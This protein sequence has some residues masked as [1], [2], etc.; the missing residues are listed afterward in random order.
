MGDYKKAEPL[1]ER[2][3]KIR[4]KVLGPEHHDTATALNNVASL[5]CHMGNYGKAEPLYERSLKILEKVLGP[6]HPN[7][8]D[9]LNNLAS[10]YQN[11]GYYKIAEPLYERSLKI[12]EKAL[13][14]EHPGTAGSLNNLAELC[15]SMGDYGKAEPLHER[16]LKILEK[17]LGPEHAETGVSYRN[18]AVC[19]FFKDGKGYEEWVRKW[20]KTEKAVWE[21]V[22]SFTSERQ[23]MAFQ[24][25]R[26]PFSLPMSLGMVP[27]SVDAL[28]RYK[29]IVLDSMMEDSRLGRSSGNP[30]VEKLVDA[31][32]FAVAKLNKV[33]QEAEKTQSEEERQQHRKE[34]EAVKAEVEGIQKELARKV[35]GHGK[36]R[37]SL[38]IV[39]T[40][41]QENLKTQE[42]L[43]EFIRYN[44]SYK[45]GGKEKKEA[46]YGV[47]LIPAKGIALKGKKAG[48]V[49]F[50]IA[51][52]AEEI[53]VAMAIGCMTN[54]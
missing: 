20:A 34:V 50:V 36:S 42:V 35:V 29:G 8:A 52:K 5:Y 41:V 26:D 24:S 48:E 43:L 44:H 1:H 2:S 10:L 16:S 11:M 18:M 40:D 14:P 21:G 45:E 51:G 9:P 38:G 23:R 7:T 27:E 32:R 22:F 39:P 54:F 6:D 46:R 33:E 3:L 15:D 37:R 53:E 49:G 19:Q 25:S 13:G 17:I 30:E 31:G 28:L 4:E 12:Y 47:S